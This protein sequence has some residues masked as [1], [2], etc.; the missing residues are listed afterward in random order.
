M[1]S[2]TVL[3]L[4]DEPLLTDALDAWDTAGLLP[5]EDTASQNVL[6]EKIYESRK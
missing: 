3:R 5:G 2:F 6:L 1:L 4:D